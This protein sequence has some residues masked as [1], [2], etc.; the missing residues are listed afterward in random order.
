[1]KDINFI[2]EQQKQNNNEPITHSKHKVKISSKQNPL[3]KTYIQS[4]SETSAL[5]EFC[6]L[7]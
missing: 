1:M 6:P 2:S 3:N 7:G 4:N 5:E